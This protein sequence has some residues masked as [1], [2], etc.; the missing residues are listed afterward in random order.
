MNNKVKAGRF[1]PARSDYIMIAVQYSKTSSGKIVLMGE[2]LDAP[3]VMIVKTFDT[4]D[5]A[6]DYADNN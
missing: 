6:I 1:D 3:G 4:L 2:K 5:Q